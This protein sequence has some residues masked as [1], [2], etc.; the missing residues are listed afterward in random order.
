MWKLMVAV[1][2]ASLLSGAYAQVYKT[3]DKY[4]NI[5]YSDKPSSGSKEIYVPPA[6]EPAPAPSK[7]G[8]SSKAKEEKLL[9]PPDPPVRYT[10]RITAPKPDSVMRQNA[11]NV[12]VAVQIKPR[13]QGKDKVQ[14]L[15]DGGAAG[16][17]SK[18]LRT[19]LKNIDRGTHSIGARIVGSKGQTKAT[20]KPVTVH[21]QRFFKAPGG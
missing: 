9:E 3:R 13:L 6:P 7:A 2:C 19:E 10:I 17:P 11:G 18:G 8:S 1:L 4:G 14:F 16:Q 21:L 5:I 12:A 15:L 20:A